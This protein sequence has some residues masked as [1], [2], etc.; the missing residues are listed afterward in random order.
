MNALASIVVKEAG[1]ST[2]NHKYLFSIFSKHVHVLH[3]C[4]VFSYWCCLRSKDNSLLSWHCLST[5]AC[6]A[7]IYDKF[8]QLVKHL[9]LFSKLYIY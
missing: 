1:N 7:E 5:V 3:V 2:Y 6:N 8:N 9:W 4:L